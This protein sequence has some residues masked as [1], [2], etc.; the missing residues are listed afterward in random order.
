MLDC[1]PAKIAEYSER[2]S[3]EFWQLRTPLTRNKVANC[4][5]ALDNGCFSNFNEKAWRAMLDEADDLS[6]DF[7]KPT[8]PKFVTL[9]DCVGS[10]QRTRELFDIFYL[11]TVG[12][13]RALVIQ[14]GIANVEI[15]WNQ[16][17]TIFVGGT[18]AFKV[19]RECMDA[20]KVGKL[21]GK[22]I[23]VGRVNTW[24]RV[25]NWVG[26]ADS[27]DGS[28]MSRFDARLEEV[29][30]YIKNEN[31]QSDFLMH[32]QKETQNG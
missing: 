21:L 29:L 4:V 18:D 14:D 25:R 6:C 17:S 31:P 23:H 15:P 30:T 27:V 28:G 16:I 3:Y 26:I 9:P 13:K 8:P 22:W 5:W 7:E 20:C 12:F 24:R 1:S 10:A 32:E 19:S 2:Y 11:Q